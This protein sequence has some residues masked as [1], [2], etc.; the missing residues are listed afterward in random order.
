VLTASDSAHDGWVSTPC[1]NWFPRSLEELEKLR[2]NLKVVLIGGNS[3][4]DETLVM[5]SGGRNARLRLT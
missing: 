5:R 1:D 4:H 2:G 3:D